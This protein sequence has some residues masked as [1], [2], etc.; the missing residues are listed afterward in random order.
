MKLE[1]T[2]PGFRRMQERLGPEAAE[3]LRLDTVKLQ[4]DTRK[5]IDS[6]RKEAERAALAAFKNRKR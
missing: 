3:I 5:L 1:R 4:E 6:V 2:S